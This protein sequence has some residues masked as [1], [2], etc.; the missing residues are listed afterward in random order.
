MKFN[1]EW[2]L[3]HRMPKNATLQQRMEWHMEHQKNCNC[4]PIPAK[5]VAEINAKNE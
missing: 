1:R 5:I 2:H 4:R 3:T